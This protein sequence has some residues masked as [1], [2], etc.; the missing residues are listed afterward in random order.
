MASLELRIFADRVKN[1][2]PLFRLVVQTEPG[3][4]F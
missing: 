3:A 1:E 2:G 4:M